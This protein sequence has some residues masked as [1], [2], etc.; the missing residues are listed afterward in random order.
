[1]LLKKRLRQSR[2][3]VEYHLADLIAIH[4]LRRF[5]CRPYFHQLT[6]FC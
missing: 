1:M 6:L 4:S 5:A 3:G 2:L